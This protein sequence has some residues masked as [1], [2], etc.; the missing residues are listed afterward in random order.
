MHP[1]VVL[2]WNGRSIIPLET[3][4]ES[5]RHPRGWRWCKG[6]G[7]TVVLVG[8]RPQVEQ[9]MCQGVAGR[10]GAGRLGCASGVGCAVAENR[11]IRSF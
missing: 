9:G 2:G 8:S 1:L 3:T 5:R 4:R 7:L 11:H 6:R 10:E